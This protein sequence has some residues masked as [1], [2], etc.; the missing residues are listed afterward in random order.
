MNYKQEDRTNGK[1][2]LTKFYYF[3]LVLIILGFFCRLLKLHK[4]TFK[5]FSS[6]NM[7]IDEKKITSEKG[8]ERINSEKKFLINFL[9]N[10][11][12]DISQ[13]YVYEPLTP[14]NHRVENY[15]N[16]L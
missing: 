2:G 11:Y 6:Y 3:P 15:R 5:Y 10:A 14:E 7:K 1:E 12:F 9:S 16:R 8:K 4:R 13:S